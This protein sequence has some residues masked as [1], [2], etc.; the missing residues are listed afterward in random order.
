M[1]LQLFLPWWS[2][3]LAAGLVG[4]TI[5]RTGFQSFLS[6]FLGTAIVWWSYA[7]MIDI[8]NQSILSTRIA[9]LFNV[10][11]PA[12]LILVSGLIAGVVGGLAAVCGNELK[13]LW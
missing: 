6:G 9:A 10:G 11:N 7:W 1:V 4:A 13:K 8:K 12:L 2:I 5:L 3:L